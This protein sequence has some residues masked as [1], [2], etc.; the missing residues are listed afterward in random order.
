MRKEKLELPAIQFNEGTNYETYKMMKLY[1]VSNVGK[2]MWRFRCWAP[3]AVSVSIIGDF[4]EWNRDANPMKKIYGGI[5]E[6][7]AASLKRF[8]NYKFSIETASGQILNKTDPFA[9]HTETPPGSAGKIYDLTGYRWND[10]KYLSYV[11][12]RNIYTSPMN[13]YELHVGSWKRHADGNC[14]SY[15]DLA[16]N[17]IPYL[18]EMGYTHVELMPITEFPYD[19]SWGYQVTGLFAPSSRFGTPHDFMYFVDRCH[20]SGIGVIMDFV[21]SHFPK[22]SYGLYEFDG[23]PLYEYQD[24]FKREHKTWGTRVFDYGR[25]AV[26][27]FLISAVCFWLE[28]YHIDGMRLDAVASMLYL[29]YDRQP[30]EWTPNIHGGNYNL[31]AIAFLK[32]LNSVV[33]T[34]F[35]YVIMIAEES[36]AFPMVTLPPDVDGLG[37]NFKWN[38][39]WMND[40][41]SYIRIDPF[42]R[43]GS[44]D[45][46]TFSLTYA[47]SENYILP[48]S[49]DE[50]VHGKA[51]MI[52]KMAGD[53]DSKFAALKALYAFQYAHPGKKLNFMGNEFGQFIEWDYTKELDWLLLQYE[54]HSRLKTF[55]KD[56]NHVYLNHS[57]LYEKDNTYEGFKWIIVDD[58]IQNII[59]FERK[60][61][62][63]L[64]LIAIINFS[65]VMRASYEVGVPESGEYEIIINSNGL[66]YG[67]NGPMQANIKTVLKENHGFK[68]SL[69]L[70]LAG[71]SALYI[72]KKAIVE[73]II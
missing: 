7:F 29:D 22:D 39:G 2:K 57:E 50:V 63:G 13:I 44:H 71:N 72:A 58:N 3:N 68:Q 20:Q 4:N 54:N 60:N 69:V 46:L 73:N 32:K 31:E 27:S 14:Y 23:K 35:P 33:L 5:W 52:S 56:L 55:I 66:L 11:K 59:A 8:D 61:N 25:P 15:R 28:Y 41:L 12:T 49:H 26:Q 10:D 48:F 16:E 34:R 6:G 40:I 19:G 24:E 64:S 42:F 30:G 38:M 65:D 17:L 21:I 9:V 43:K 70:N 45:K 18:M 51:S 67:G 36:T 53:Y 47:F 37:F 1:Y 62:A